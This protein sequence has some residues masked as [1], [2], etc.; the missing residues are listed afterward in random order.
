MGVE[1]GGT[2]VFSQFYCILKGWY[3]VEFCFQ[4]INTFVHLRNQSAG[5]IIV[6]TAL[7]QTN[8]IAYVR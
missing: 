1:V 7:P 6:R 4:H 3:N 8:N 5:G 2:T